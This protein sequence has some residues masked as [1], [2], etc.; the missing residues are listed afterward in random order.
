MPVH[1]GGRYPPPPAVDVTRAPCVRRA[2]WRRWVEGFVWCWAAAAPGGRGGLSPGEGFSGDACIERRRLQ[3]RMS[4]QHLDHAH[5]DALLQEMGGEAVAQ[6]MGGDAFG[7]L[8]VRCG[9]AGA[10]ELARRH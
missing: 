7:N 1:G 9:V 8:G 4:E 6:R 2:A 10:G 5:I 3:L